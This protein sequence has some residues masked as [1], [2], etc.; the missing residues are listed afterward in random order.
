MSI[1]LSYILLIFYALEIMNIKI[2]LDSS[3]ILLHFE[4]LISPERN[5]TNFM[6]VWNIYNLVLVFVKCSNLTIF[7]ICKYLF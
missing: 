5:H 3:H 2:I 6:L 1:F 7:I 4:L